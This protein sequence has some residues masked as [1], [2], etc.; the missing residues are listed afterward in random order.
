MQSVYWNLSKYIF[1]I[2]LAL[3]K[4]M[5]MSNI[6]VVPRWDDMKT[7]LSHLFST[8]YFMKYILQN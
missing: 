3:L 2:Q 7:H 1:E 4:I 6:E 8:L 5:L